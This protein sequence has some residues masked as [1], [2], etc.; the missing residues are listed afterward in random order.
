MRRL[1]WLTSRAAVVITST[2]LTL[3]LCAG[4]YEIVEQVQYDRWRAGFDNAGWF[5]KLTIPSPNPVLMWEYRPYGSAH[6]IR[7]NRYG[8]RDFDYET[9]SLPPN[10]FRVAF[11]GDSAV[12]G[13]GVAAEKTFVSQFEVEANAITFV[14]KTHR[15]VSGYHVQAMNFAV[16]GYHTAQIREMI[17]AKVLD[18]SPHKIVYVM[19]LNDFDFCWSSGSKI[20]YFRRPTSFALVKFEQWYQ[21]WEGDD[22]HRYHF[23]KRR[24]EVFRH[25]LGMKDLLAEFGTRFQVVLLP[26]FSHH[27]RDY[28][29]RD[30]HE[31]IG[32]F[33][34][35]NDIPF[36][37]LLGAFDAAGRP[38]GDFASDVWHPNVAG[39]HFIARQLL[40]AVLL[41]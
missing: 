34:K 26:V 40:P 3:I 10:T 8:F 37:D 13:I 33:T 5:G 32:I 18:F 35:E 16:D 2:L 39:H 36:F 27:F 14:D 21:L 23:R 22:Y 12:L 28:P 1:P 41:N 17:R 29:V 31:Q 25:L 6:L 11:A 4:T 38:P 9:K 19:H 24:E 20:L 15:E 7:T 30:V